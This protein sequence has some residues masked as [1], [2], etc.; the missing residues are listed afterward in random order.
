MYVSS[1]LRARRNSRRFD[2]LEQ[3]PSTLQIHRGWPERLDMAPPEGSFCAPPFLSSARPRLPLA[4]RRRE[5][6]NVGVG[7]T[8][9][10]AAVRL[11]LR[12]LRGVAVACHTVVDLDQLP[13]RSDA[14]VL[15]GVPVLRLLPVLIGESTTQ[16]CLL[17]GEGI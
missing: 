4:R 6:V 5:H 14:R 1:P 7:K 2:A 12:R 8:A 15:V 9:G 10:A 13:V 3:D 11:M 17:L 16:H